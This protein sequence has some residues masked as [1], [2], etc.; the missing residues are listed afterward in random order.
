MELYF[1]QTYGDNTIS[2]DED[3]SNHLLKVNRKNIGDSV[4]VTDGEGRLF[5]TQLIEKTK[6]NCI[7]EIKSV[8]QTKE[9]NQ[10]L[11]IAIAPTKS[12]DRLE[13]FLE[14][15]TESGIDEI[16]FLVCRHSERRDLKE[17]R[18]KRV[19]IAAMK[20]SL[21]TFLPKLNPV[22]DFNDF[23]KRENADLKLIFTT[24]APP[25]KNL[26]INYQKGTS[27]TALVGPEGDFHESEL[28]LAQ[29]NGYIYTTLGPS[30]LRTETA[31][32]NVCML[33]NFINSF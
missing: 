10:K 23:V 16:T 28:E 2:L 19:L 17:D 22:I 33:Y 29:N 13:W 25:E 3:E 6:R 5:T 9:R 30:R 4:F 27:L 18:L 11:H 32:I 20:Q 15:A 21:K 8:T 31:G 14:K 7:L 26:K 12:I 24:T 1:G